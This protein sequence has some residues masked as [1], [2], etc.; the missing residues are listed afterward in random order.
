VE[1]T[2]KTLIDYETTSGNCPIR[3]WLDDLDFTITARIEA[4]LKRVALGNYGDVKPVGQGVSEL[5]LKFGSGYRVYFSQ[6]GEEIIVLLC[7]G[8]KGSQTDDIETAKSYWADFKRR[9]NA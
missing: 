9:N 4:R 8:D 7:G 1:A 2:P 3:E 5:R 6:H